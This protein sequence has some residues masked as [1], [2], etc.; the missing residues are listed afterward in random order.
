MKMEN[1]L[2]GAAKKNRRP[3]VPGPEIVRSW[4]VYRGPHW[5][6]DVLILDAPITAAP[7]TFDAI[8][9]NGDQMGPFATRVEAAVA[10]GAK[11][12]A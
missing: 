6:G 12:V 5:L 8:T 4:P 9:R 7:I 2:L 1:R 11:A 10:I 3:A